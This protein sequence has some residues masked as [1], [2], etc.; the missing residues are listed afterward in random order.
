M[1]PAVKEVIVQTR[2]TARQYKAI[3]RAAEARSLSVAGY[4]RFVALQ[5]ATG[6]R[7]H[8][9]A[10][11]YDTDPTEWRA[12]GIAPDYILHRVGVSAGGEQTFHMLHGAGRR[13][14]VPLSEQGLRDKEFFNKADGYVFVLEG[15]A[16]RWL[17]VRTTYVTQDEDSGAVELVIRPEGTQPRDAVRARIVAAR[18]HA[19]TFELIG[20]DRMTGSVDAWAAGAHTFD[21]KLA[22]GTTR[23]IHYDRVVAFGG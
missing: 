16:D 12:R 10:A 21:L 7:V 15:S 2:V 19:L 20:G 6:T 4:L 8:A 13:Q 5:H 9:W 23:T 3:E 17:I 14:G 18:G 11:Q 1:T 22:D